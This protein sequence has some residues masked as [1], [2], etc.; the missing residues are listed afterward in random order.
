MLESIIDF[1]NLKLGLLNYFEKTHC[2]STLVKNDDGLIYPAE[3]ISNGDFNAVDF[4][5]Y[6]GVSYIRVNGEIDVERVD[7]RYTPKPRLNVTFP[8]RLVYAVRKDKLTKDD[9]Y[10]FDRVRGSLVKQLESDSADL[11][12]QLEADRI[13]VSTSNYISDT[14]ELWD[15]ETA[16]TGTFQPKYEVVFGAMEV[17]VTVTTRAECIPSECDDFESDILRTFD[18]CKTNTQD[19]LTSTQVACLTDWLCGSPDPAT[20]QVNGVT[21]T[22]IPSGDTYDLAI[23]NSAGTDVGTVA[24]PSIVGDSTITI[25]SSSLSSTGDVEAEGSLNLEVT[26]N[27]APVGSWNAVDE[28]WQIPSD[29]CPTVEVTVYSDSGFTNPITDADFNDTV[30]IKLVPSNF[31]PT[32]YRIIF[33][34]AD[35]VPQLIYEGANDNSSWVVSGAIG[36][37][38]FFGHATDDNEEWNGQSEDFT[39]NAVNY[40][41]LTSV[42]PIYGVSVARYLKGSFIGS[43][44]VLVRRSSDN[45]QQGFTVDE[46][47]DGTLE[48]WVGAGNDGLVVTLYDQSGNGNDRTISTASWQYYLVSSGTLNTD[49]NG[50]PKMLTTASTSQVPFGNTTFNLGDTNGSFT[51]VSQE[52]RGQSFNRYWATLRQGIS[53][54]IS[55]GFY[56]LRG[57]VLGS[58]STANA[59]VGT[60]TFYVNNVDQ[61]SYNTGDVYTQ[62]GN[63][64]AITELLDIDFSA[65]AGWLTNFSEFV[66][67]WNSELSEFVL[68]DDDITA[69]RTTLHTNAQTFYGY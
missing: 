33:E 39:I 49:S 29:S 52:F 25:N 23:H 2:L 11:A 34:S 68:W 54:N 18:F 16:E 35:N 24:N 56:A 13:V 10:S 51:M 4:D 40:L 6:D 48:T 38:R 7:Q 22:N 31:T 17:S 61:G 27:G 20:L 5:A 42:A 15:E 59:G 57:D 26:Q 47:T 37:G 50:N 43:D 41:D 8:L 28:E 21:L 9:A 1:I 46:I 44:V 64:E 36:A 63:T 19:R 60:P 66:M 53:T 30:Y 45:A 65:N 32:N 55:A 62:I 69:D 67:A 3:Y 14:K 58:T 12:N